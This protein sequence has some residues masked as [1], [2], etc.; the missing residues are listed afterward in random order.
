MGNIKPILERIREAGDLTPNIRGDQHYSRA[1][2]QGESIAARQWA[3]P[4]YPENEKKWIDE[5]EVDPDCPA[6]AGD[7]SACPLHDWNWR[8]CPHAM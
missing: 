5:G 2:E 7:A 8:A 4:H 6:C 1:N 3:L